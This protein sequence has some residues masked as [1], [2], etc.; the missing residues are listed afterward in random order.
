MVRRMAAQTPIAVDLSKLDLLMFAK[1]SDIFSCSAARRLPRDAGSGEK[2]P[3]AHG[4][5]S[6]GRHYI[7]RA[8]LG[9]V[10]V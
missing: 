4:R 6:G 5:Y 2:R 3:L 10:S 9:T 1:C 7:L 8:P